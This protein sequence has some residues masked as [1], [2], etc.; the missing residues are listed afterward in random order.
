MGLFFFWGGYIDSPLR[1][2][3]S[4]VVRRAQ[5]SSCVSATHHD[6]DDDDNNNDNLFNVSS[7]G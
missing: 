6:R 3:R 4:N 5:L 2:G 7:F 1:F